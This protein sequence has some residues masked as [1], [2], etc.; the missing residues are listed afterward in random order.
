[1]R[2]RGRAGNTGGKACRRLVISS[3]RL[4]PFADQLVLSECNATAQDGNEFVDLRP[5]DGE[6]RRHH[7]HVDER[8]Y[9]QAQALAMGVDPFTHFEVERQGVVALP[10]GD[11][12]DA[13][14][15]PEAANFAHERQILERLQL[16]LEIGCDVPDMG[17]QAAFQQI[18][19]GFRDGAADRM[20]AIGQAVGEHGV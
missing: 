17:Q 10:I 2:C 4:Q 18:K 12:F 8:S 11:T 1:M 3:R 5:G 20:A 9:K 15:Q 13:G 7:A 14:H 19:I 6:G 16:C